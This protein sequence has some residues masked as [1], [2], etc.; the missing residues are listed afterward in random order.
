[1]PS[2][3]TLGKVLLVAS[4]LVAWAASATPGELG[5]EALAGYLE[6][7]ASNSTNAVFGSSGGLTWGGAG[8]FVFDSGLY[9][10][11]GV[12]TFSKDGERVFVS[13]QGRPVAKLGHPLSL[14]VT[15]VF[16]TAGYRFRHGAMVVPYAGVGGS[17]TSYSEDSSVAGISYDESGSKAGFHVVGGVEVGRGMVRFGAEAGWATVP[18]ALGLGGVSK[19]YD[20][21]DLGG[22]TVLGKVILAFGGGKKDDDWLPD[23][24]PK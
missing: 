18:N 11:G 3:K 6:M 23:H 21:D 14:R 15:P 19:V 12:R 4:A 16:L 24:A 7:T 2:H 22:W 1:M 9:V 20:E 5:V 10:A 8:R 13:A 17:L